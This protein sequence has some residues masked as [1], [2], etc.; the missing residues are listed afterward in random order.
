MTA[1]TTIQRE[2]LT[3]LRKVKDEVAKLKQMLQRSE[4]K[5]QWVTGDVIM[6][7]YGITCKDLE[8]YR[9]Q[10]II[11]FKQERKYKVRY[12]LQSAEK[13]FQNIKSKS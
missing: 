1:D 11:K 10:N 4:A 8:H 5:D 3:E 6:K 9:K 7:L 12:S 13:L 2:I